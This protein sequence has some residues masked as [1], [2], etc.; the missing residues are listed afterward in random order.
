MKANLSRPGQN[1]NWIGEGCGRLGKPSLTSLEDYHWATARIRV[2][3]SYVK[4]GIISSSLFCSRRIQYCRWHR[5]MAVHSVSV[6]LGLSIRFTGTSFNCFSK[7]FLIYCLFSLNQPTGPM[8]SI[9]LYYP[10]QCISPH[11]NPAS[12]WTGDFWLKSI[13][14]IYACL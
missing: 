10:W 2:N 9:K 12:W 13:L 1:I 8:Q 11:G 3:S 7:Q 4:G 14:L 5:G 6:A